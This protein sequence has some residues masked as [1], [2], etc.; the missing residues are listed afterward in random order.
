[1]GGRAVDAFCGAASSVA[2]PT[3]YNPAAAKASHVEA[4]M[5]FRQATTSPLAV[6]YQQAAFNKN[7]AA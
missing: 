3:R 5:N 4:L 2:A 1:V 6:S 7:I